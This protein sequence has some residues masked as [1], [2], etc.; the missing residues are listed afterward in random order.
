MRCSSDERLIDQP[1]EKGNA[2]WRRDLAWYQRTD[3]AG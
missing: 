2:Q 3:I 1:A